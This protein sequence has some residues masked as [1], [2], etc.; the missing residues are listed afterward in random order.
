MILQL[1]KY[2]YLAITSNRRKL[3]L[4]KNND[5][6]FYQSTLKFKIY[7]PLL[8]C[9]KQYILF[10]SGGNQKVLFFASYTWQEKINL[11][12]I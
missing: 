5:V 8:L 10:F 3:K 7:F 11:S 12:D 9:F 2:I 6:I 1:T 4:N